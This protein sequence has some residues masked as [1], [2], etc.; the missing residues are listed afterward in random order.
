[1]RLQLLASQI[2]GKDNREVSKQWQ[3]LQ[4]TKDEH[5]PLRHNIQPQIHHTCFD[6]YPLRISWGNLIKDQSILPLTIILI[7]FI[8]VT[9]LFFW[10]CFVCVVV[11]F[12]TWSNLIFLCFKLVII[13]SLPLHADLSVYFR[14]GHNRW[15][16]Y[17][18]GSIYSSGISLRECSFW[19]GLKKVRFY[20]GRLRTE[21]KGIEQ[22]LN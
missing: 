13:H 19:L 5:Q 14:N 18:E 11:Q 8:H 3:Q 9:R 6:T 4:S 16:L 22:W 1:M 12:Y 17:P 15:I 7:I 2:V 21:F 20:G 10:L